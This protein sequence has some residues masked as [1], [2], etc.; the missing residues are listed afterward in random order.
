MPLFP[1][2]GRLK[3]KTDNELLNMFLQNKD[4][5]ILGELYGRYMQLVYGV[6]LKYLKNRDDSKDAV[7][8]IFEKVH[9]ELGKHK[10]QT[11]KAWLYVLTKNHCLMQ[12][13]KNKQQ[14]KTQ[15]EENI[16]IFMEKGEEIHPIDRE[17]KN[18]EGAL[19]DCI[20]KLKKEQKACI[21]LFY[22]E[23][24]CYNE[25][26]KKLKIEEKKVKSHIQNGKRNL[27]ICLDKQK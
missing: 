27:K 15:A 7:I 5:D 4:M 22:F 2:K 26:A 17:E 24:K 1:V 9:L 25:V 21:H 19:M 18:M 11:F 13:R 8:Q 6:C 3:Y 10:I 23:N 16:S 20:G 12:L 14:F